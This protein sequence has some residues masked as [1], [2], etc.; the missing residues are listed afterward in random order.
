[1]I[2]DILLPL[3]EDYILSMNILGKGGN[4]ETFYHINFVNFIIMY[5]L[6]RYDTE[7]RKAPVGRPIW[8]T[9]APHGR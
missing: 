8:G 9:G 3:D 2:F 7:A 1:L 6:W 5:W 4:I